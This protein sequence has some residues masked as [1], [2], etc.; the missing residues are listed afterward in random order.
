MFSVQPSASEI[1][2]S[3]VSST[4]NMITVPAGRW[5]TGNVSISASVAVAGNSSPVVTVNG[6][7]AAPASGT[8]VARLNLV[9]LALTTVAGSTSTEIIVKA[10]TSNDVTIDFTAGAAGTSSATVNGFVYG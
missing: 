2:C 6:T 7:N 8:V 9:G 5:Y 1:M 3:T 10:P 4:G